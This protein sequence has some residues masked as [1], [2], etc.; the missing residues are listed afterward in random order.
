MKS[1]D[2]ILRFG[3]NLCT[4]DNYLNCGKCVLW[5]KNKIFFD[6]NCNH[7]ICLTN[8]DAYQN[9]FMKARNKCTLHENNM[10]QVNS[11]AFL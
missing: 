6:C 1:Y 10:K 3:C 4:T 11:E 7:I 5:Q 9:V 2:C 8:K